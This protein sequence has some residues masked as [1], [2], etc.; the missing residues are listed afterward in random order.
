MSGLSAQGAYV[1]VGGNL[2]LW[3]R[4]AAAAVEHKVG[5]RGVAMPDQTITVSKGRTNPPFLFAS[6]DLEN[7]TKD[8]NVTV[9]VEGLGG[10][11]RLRQ[12]FLEVRQDPDAKLKFNVPVLTDQFATQVIEVGHDFVKF[13]IRRVDAPTGWHQKLKVQMLLILEQ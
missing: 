3:L 12:V 5:K 13:R 1:P 6:V 4:S 10:V 2:A 9:T 8:P 11:G 7:K